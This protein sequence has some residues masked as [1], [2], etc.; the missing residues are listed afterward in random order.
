MRYTDRS[1]NDPR[2]RFRAGESP[3]GWAPFK[4]VNGIGDSGAGCCCGDPGDVACAGLTARTGRANAEPIAVA[5]PASDVG[6]NM[7]AMMPPKS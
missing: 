4:G 2:G 7:A 3:P 6:D 5:R 1:S